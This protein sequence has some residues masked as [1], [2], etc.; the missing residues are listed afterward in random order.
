MPPWQLT[1]ANPQI[2][3]FFNREIIEVSVESRRVFRASSETEQRYMH[4][5]HL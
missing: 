5:A 2:T 1:C 4:A 3:V